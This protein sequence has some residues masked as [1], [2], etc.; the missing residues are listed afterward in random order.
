MNEPRLAGA[1][2]TQPVYLDHQAS[3]PLDPD[4]LEAMLPWLRSSG[5]NPHS[6][7]NSAGR[8]ALDAI[9]QAR[10]AVAALVGARP[11]NVVFTA[12][13]TEATNLVLRSLAGTGARFAAS[14]IEHPCVLATLDDL[15]TAGAEIE[16]IAID[17]DGIIELD[18]VE[19][20]LSARC[21]L[22]SVMA[23]NNEIGTIQ[24]V[25][26]VGML[27]RAAGTLFHCDAVQAA[28]RIMLDL[29]TDRIDFAALSAHK[30][31]GPQGIG[32]LCCSDD[33]RRML[34]P[35][36]TGGG[37]EQGLRSGTLPVALCVGF[38]RACEIAR[39]RLDA[40]AAHAQALS[41]TLLRILAK[42]GTGAIVNGSRTERVP[43]NLSLRFD[44]I[45]ADALLAAVP[46]LQ[47]STGSA[48]SSGA[49]GTSHVLAAIGLSP[50]E[51][52]STIRVGLGRRTTEEQI[53]M[54]G[55]AIAAAVEMLGGCVGEGQ[56]RYRA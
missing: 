26:E 29:E 36:V 38:G 50:E 10:D 46:Q 34:R 56:Y 51:A 11:A 9:E 45:D 42:A 24:P 15:E 1:A 32:A 49:I 7:E 18:A 39:Q 37:Q 23:V 5:A 53:V 47:L 3:T 25:A 54:A 40:D 14:A 43:H 4:V 13:A 41:E 44:G 12:G 33:G 48:C 35:L 55:H 22:L 17:A 27:A 21:T 2:L 52:A 28:G 30:I 20:A 16:S 8:S 31:Y 6:T 19:A